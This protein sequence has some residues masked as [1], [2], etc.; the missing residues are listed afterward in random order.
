[1]EILNT[2]DKII[3]AMYELLAEKGYDK[4]SIGQ[5]ANMI[6]IKKASV[7]YYFRFKEEILLE[8]TKRLYSIDD[9]F[10]Q[11]DP[12]INSN[13]LYKQYLLSEGYSFIEFYLNNLKLRKVYAEIDIQTNRIVIL[14]DFV[15]SYNL[16]VKE[17]WKKILLFGVELGVFS[18]DFLVESNAEFLFTVITGIDDALLYELPIDAKKV[19]E[20]TI[21]NLL[22]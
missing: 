3:M 11:P 20:V 22:K 5:I 2:R 17:K 21:T 6:G 7:Y 4:S 13:E 8:L 16:K 9:I 10:K 12:E 14:R 18:K 15:K 19:W 1:M